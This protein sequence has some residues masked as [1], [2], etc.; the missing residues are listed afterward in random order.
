MGEPVVNKC[1]PADAAKTLDLTSRASI[2]ATCWDWLRNGQELYKYIRYSE[3]T[4]NME[5][6]ENIGAPKGTG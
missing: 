4:I 3:P 5:L 2:L 6:P 1:T